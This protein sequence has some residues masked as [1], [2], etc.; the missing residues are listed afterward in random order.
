MK[1]FR[2]L[3]LFG[4][5]GILVVALAFI[6]MNFVQA[7]VKGQRKG[8][9]PGKEKEPE[10]LW[11]AII[12][13]DPDTSEPG[14]NLLGEE[15]RLDWDSGFFGYIYIDTDDPGNDQDNIRIFGNKINYSRKGGYST[16]FSY[17]NF[18]VK[19]DI[20]VQIWDLSLSEDEDEDPISNGCGFPEG[21]C[22]SEFLNNSHPMEGYERIYFGFTSPCDF[23]HNEQPFYEPIKLRMH[24]Q[25]DATDDDCSDSYCLHSIEG[26][27]H[28]CSPN[29]SGDCGFCPGPEGIPFI[30]LERMGTDVWKVYVHTDFNMQESDMIQEKYFDTVVVEEPVGK[31]GKMKEVTKRMP[32]YPTWGRG[33]MAFQIVFIRSQI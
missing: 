17:F 28:G 24:F 4:L 8:K 3:K 2:K 20:Q 19:H 21:S 11:R 16:V 7:E 9:P 31:R 14:G 32:L 5:V 1:K 18:E 33:H 25:I 10:Y 30:Y 13:Q 26:N 27:A 29:E 15:G 22:L 12:L 6:G 23:N